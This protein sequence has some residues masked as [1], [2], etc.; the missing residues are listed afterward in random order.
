MS[1]SKITWA[2]T[3]LVP[4]YP[5]VRLIWIPCWG[6]SLVSG[7]CSRREVVCNLTSHHQM[8]KYNVCEW[9]VLYKIIQHFFTIHVCWWMATFSTTILLQSCGLRI[10]AKTINDLVVTCLWATCKFGLFTWVFYI[11]SDM[12]GLYQYHINI[13][14]YVVYSYCCIS[15]SSH[16][17]DIRTVVFPPTTSSVWH[18]VPSVTNWHGNKTL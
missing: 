2:Y 18:V 3:I 9:C 8:I 14:Q 4:Q 12:Y 1:S 10:V 13:L 16:C 5:S 6:C 15:S 11:V 7:V 17:I